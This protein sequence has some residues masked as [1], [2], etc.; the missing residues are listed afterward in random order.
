MSPQSPLRRIGRKTKLLPK[1]LAMFPTDITLFIDLFMGAGVVSFA[2]VDRVKYVIANDKDADIF[3][4]FWVWK[5][6]K[7]DLIEACTVMP[8]HQALWQHWKSHEETDPVWRA[9]RF[10]MR[11]N[12]GYLGKTDTLKF[13]IGNDKALLLQQLH[14]CFRHIRHI[15]FLTHDFRDALGCVSFRHPER[16]KASTLLYLDPPYLGTGNNYVHGFT[17]QDTGDCFE[18]AVNSGMRFAMSEFDHPF[19]LDLAQQH[20]LQV[21]DLGTRRTLKNRRREI[22]ITNYDPPGAML[23]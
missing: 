5:E 10:L 2:M 11:S 6:R 15:Q 1:L 19:V 21:H 14:A 12:F 7:D 4:L 16:D 18:V 3:N 17:E 13:G 20:G 9:A 22:L 8:Y 23:L